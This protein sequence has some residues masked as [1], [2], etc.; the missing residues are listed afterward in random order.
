MPEPGIY[1]PRPPL[2]L[3][4]GEFLETPE[5]IF[6]RATAQC[7]YRRACGWS[8]RWCER[9]QPWDISRWPPGPGESS[10]QKNLEDIPS[11]WDE[12]HGNMEEREPGVRH[13]WCPDQPLPPP[14]PHEADPSGIRGR[15]SSR[16]SGDKGRE[17]ASFGRG[18]PAAPPSPTL[19]HWHH[20]NQRSY[21]DMST[22]DI[23]RTKKM[24]GH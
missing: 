20:R 19:S 14:R 11:R 23:R 17:K 2:D 22:E 13:C 4:A 5:D 16:V 8:A 15:K 1:F 6:R 24:N 12:G 21:K 18:L 7:K 3:W 9:F 10:T